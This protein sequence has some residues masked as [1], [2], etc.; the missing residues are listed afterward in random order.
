MLAEW[1]SPFTRGAEL[2]FKAI[3]TPSSEI[4]RT[5]PSIAPRE[6]RHAQPGAFCSI[7][8]SRS[9]PAEMQQ[10]AH[11]GQ[12]PPAAC[13]SPRGARDGPAKVRMHSQTHERRRERERKRAYAFYLACKRPY[14]DSS[15]TKTCGECTLTLIHRSPFFNRVD[16]RRF[17]TT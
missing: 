13:P 5:R 7:L 4:T 11:S 6:G 8:S 2:I 10:V 15:S 16:T 9:F 3:R 17:V 14:I 12:V 1:N